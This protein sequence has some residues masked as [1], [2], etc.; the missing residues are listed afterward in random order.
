[1]LPHEEETYWTLTAAPWPMAAR[2]CQTVSQVC[3]TVSQEASSF[4]LHNWAVGQ[5]E[6]D[7]KTNKFSTQDHQK[8]LVLR[9]SW[10][11][12]GW[13]S[14]PLNFGHVCLV[15]KFVTTPCFKSQKPSTTID[16]LRILRLFLLYS[17]TPTHPPCGG[18]GSAALDTCSLSL[19]RSFLLWPERILCAR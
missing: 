7:G 16:A 17:F 5:L 1:M 2:V 8:W 18:V 10:R 14:A 15:Q 6:K 13:L 9:W 19:P 3:Q 12:V 4:H 11:L